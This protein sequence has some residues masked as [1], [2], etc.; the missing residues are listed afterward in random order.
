[1]Q[2]L[3]STQEGEEN[4]IA[5]AIFFFKTQI[6][7]QVTWICVA[8]LE[9]MIL[10]RWWQLLF[11]WFLTY[12]LCWMVDRL[13]ISLIEIFILSGELLLSLPNLLAL[14]I[15]KDKKISEIFAFSEFLSVQTKL[16]LEF[17]FF[18]FFS[19]WTKL[20]LEFPFF[21]F[22]SVWISKR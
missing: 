4:D 11:Q 17:P 21:K 16:K 10:S 5:K 18:H 22:F 15:K 1:M 13:N 9:S 19:V 7:L 3:H 12:F 20:K 8:Q 6:N 14:H 2:V